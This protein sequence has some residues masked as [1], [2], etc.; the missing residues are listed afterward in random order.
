MDGNIYAIKKIKL[1]QKANSEENRRIRREVN[2][3]GTLTNQYIVR[4]F[5]TWVEIETDPDKIRE[6]GFESDSNDYGSDSGSS[7][8]I[9]SEKSPSKITQPPPP[10]MQS[11]LQASSLRSDDVIATPNEEEKAPEATPDEE[12][13]DCEY[14]YEYYDEEEDDCTATRPQEV[15]VSKRSSGELAFTE[16]LGGV[17]RESPMKQRPRA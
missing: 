8:H 17:S 11:S 10:F 4:Y 13:Y 3:F 12:D 15:K 1:E 16:S 9:E 7:Q 2:F 6:L 14:G 5:Q